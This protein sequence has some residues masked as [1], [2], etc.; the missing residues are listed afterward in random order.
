MKLLCAA[1]PGTLAFTRSVALEVACTNILA[2]ALVPW[3]HGPAPQSQRFLQR[4][5]HHFG[6]PLLFC[7]AQTQLLAGHGSTFTQSCGQLQTDLRL[8]TWSSTEVS[9]LCKKYH[10]I[11]KYRRQP[12]KSPQAIV[13]VEIIKVIHM[14]YQQSFQT[15]VKNQ[16]KKNYT[17]FEK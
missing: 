9:R 4:Q 2:N 11:Q 8:S 3:R 13:S 14:N 15:T 5:P 12:S 16:H 10:P 7:P 1:W 17:P 6:H